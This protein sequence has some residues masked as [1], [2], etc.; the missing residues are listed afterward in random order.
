MKIGVNRA[1]V[2]LKPPK[3]KAWMPHSRTKNGYIIRLSLDNGYKAYRA[4]HVANYNP[5]PS[6]PKHVN[7]REIELWEDYYTYL[8]DKRQSPFQPAAAGSPRRMSSLAEARDDP[9]LD[10]RDLAEW[11]GV[12]RR[13]EGKVNVGRSIKVSG[14]AEEKELADL[15]R[16]GLLYGN[17][18]VQNVELGL[19]DIVRARPVYTVRHVAGRR[20]KEKGVPDRRGVLLAVREEEGEEAGQEVGEETDMLFVPESEFESW[21]E[22]AEENGFDVVMVDDLVSNAESWVEVDV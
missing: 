9:V 10:G 1:G 20:A 6:S 7:T 11:D 12:G 13:E 14:D 4:E 16:A 18:E 22:F 17:D 21:A 8:R 2:P 3:P 15:R 5:L 19:G